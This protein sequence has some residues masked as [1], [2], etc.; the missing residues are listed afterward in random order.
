MN[1]LNSKLDAILHNVARPARYTG[2][3][4]NE[5]K[6]DWDKTTLRLALSYPD[7]YDI[8]M[9]NM[10]IPILYQ[11][12]N[13][14][15]D[16]LCERVY[17]PWTDM[18]AEMRRCGIPLYSLETRHPVREFDVLGFSLG[19]EL[20]YTN[21]LT[22][23][24]L[25]G[26]PLFAGERG[27]N[28]PIVIAGGSAA[29]NPE[30]M[31]DFIDFYA[32]GD[33]EEVLK[34]LIELFI[35]WKKQKWTRRELLLKAA[36]IPGIYV[37]SLYEA[38][39]GSDGLFKS[40]TPLAPEAPVTVRRRIVSVL[41]PAVTKPVVPYVE[42]VHDRGALEIQ[43]GCS[44]GCR[45]CQAS[46]IYRPVRERPPQEV[47]DTIGEII[48]NCGYNEVSLVS[49]SSSD[50]PEIQQ[51]V[52][53]ALERYREERLSLQLPSLRIDNFSLELMEALS[54]GRRTG[55]T[56]APEAGTERLRHVI[57]KPITTDEILSTAGAA[58][59]K[60]W[61]GIKLYFMIGL[62]TET[63][64]DVQG[65][66]DLVEAVRTVG[67]QTGRHPQV[68]VSVSTFVPKPHT[69]FQWVGQNDEAA[70]AG[71]Q[72]I[73]THRLDRRGIRISWSDPKSSLLEA[74]L[75]RGDRRLGRVI[76]NAW[77]NGAIYDAWSELFN[78]EYWAKA[79]ADAG[80]DPASYALRDRQPDEPLPWGHIDAGVSP[81]FLARE[82]RLA[83]SGTLTPDCRF[84]PCHRCGLEKCT[85]VCQERQKS[86]S[87]D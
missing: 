73:L 29:L 24:D 53:K 11:I 35:A 70:I 62:P 38:R 23:L 32:L 74:A 72:E 69:P 17:A 64:E 75:S 33:G 7:L 2:G 86:A 43:R 46:A 83:V 42:T 15:P 60:G 68:R 25:A 78:Y 22:M 61:T 51:V 48:G 52:D 13:D 30:P 8:G 77:K 55:L 19:Y 76:Y 81:E 9:S 6:K 82:Y 14:N 79:F 1:N 49:L 20:T 26:I 47:I 39:Y 37:P 67:N 4:W 58:F 40:I 85:V 12:A 87:S 44:R 63:A 16:T 41:G 84:T 28:D 65:I 10:G 5:I 80:L 45:F 59:E 27:E 31:S 3:E 50:Y 56:F 34:E 21:V 71:K 57:N 36:G 66:A 54:E 18:L